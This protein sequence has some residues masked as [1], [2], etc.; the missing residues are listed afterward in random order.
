M[1]LPQAVR[2]SLPPTLN[3]ITSLIHGTSLAAQLGA[4]ELLESG[5]RSIQR[6][7]LDLGDGHGLA[8]FGAVLIVFFLVCY[9]L[10][11]TS[12]W[13]ERRLQV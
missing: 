6:L 10:V 3:L 8:I 12:R 1:I 11:V 4:L 9:P 5:R 13:L 2:R 7:V